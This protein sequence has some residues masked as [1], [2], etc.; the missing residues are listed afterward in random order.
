MRAEQK[1]RRTQLLGESRANLFDTPDRTPL[2]ELSFFA[3][4]RWKGAG[5]NPDVE[6][7]RL[8][9]DQG[10]DHPR[11]TAKFYMQHIV[12]RFPCGT[13]QGKGNFTS[14]LDGNVNEP[15]LLGRSD[16]GEFGFLG[17]GIDVHQQ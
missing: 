6:V 11:K 13:P 7:R 9:A 15:G 8:F 16:K 4:E 2:V 17:R 12:H 5:Q 3:N 1:T 14:W 10:S